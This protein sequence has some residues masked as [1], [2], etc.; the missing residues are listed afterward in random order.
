M[1]QSVVRVS[2]VSVHPERQSVEGRAKETRGH[3]ADSRERPK[4]RAGAAGSQRAKGRVVRACIRPPSSLLSLSPLVPAVAVRGLRPCP[5]PC[6]R[7]NGVTFAAPTTG[8]GPKPAKGNTEE[9]GKRTRRKTARHGVAGPRAAAL[10]HS[11]APSFQL[12]ALGTVNFEIRGKDKW[13]PRFTRMSNSFLDP[14]R[15]SLLPCPVP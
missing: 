8:A 14:A 1:Q 11:T 9:K 2:L 10:A 5:W 13:T 12:R 3:E 4:G 7:H 15:V 6:P